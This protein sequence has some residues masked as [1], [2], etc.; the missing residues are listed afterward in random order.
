M[1]VSLSNSPA[2]EEPR[3]PLPTVSRSCGFLFPGLGACACALLLALGAAAL[4]THLQP[5]EIDN[6]YSLGRASNR[7]AFA[8]FLKQYQHAFQ[9]PPDEPLAFAKLVEF[10]TPYERIA[11]KAQQTPNYTRFD[12]VDD[13]DANPGL[14]RVRATVSLRTGY[15]GPAPSE[16][17][18]RIV[19]SQSR[20]IEPQETTKA[21]L[22]DPY[23]P[24][25]YS[26]LANCIAYTLE[27]DSDF[28]VM[29]FAAGNATP[30]MVKVVLPEGKSLETK[31]NLDKLK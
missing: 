13:Y 20:T 29:Q 4:Q 16:D 6:A 5:E 2:L 31:F 10:E 14:I 11:L 19:V 28:Q 7:E 24:Q 12:A 8:N 15:V 21:V 27:L 1:L 25:S 23:N 18:Y 26:V 17:S 22:C 9:Y 30:V 3:A